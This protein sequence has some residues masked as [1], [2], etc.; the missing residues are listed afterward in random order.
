MV[1]YEGKY[2]QI[3]RMLASVHNASVTIHRTRIGAIHLGDLAV[4]LLSQKKIFTLYLSNGRRR[5]KQ[6]RDILT[7]YLLRLLILVQ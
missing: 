2:H 3:R 4:R 1:L 6:E 5:R 7:H